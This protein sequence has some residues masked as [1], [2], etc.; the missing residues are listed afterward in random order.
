MALLTGESASRRATNFSSSNFLFSRSPRCLMTRFDTDPVSKAPPNLTF[1]WKLIFHMIL[2]IKSCFS[3]CQTT[4]AFFFNF[5]FFLKGKNKNDATSPWP[6]R[7]HNK[8]LIHQ[9]LG[10]RSSLKILIWRPVGGNPH[11]VSPPV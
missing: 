4:Q 7:Y 1:A 11:V 8:T 6:S 3:L 5:S 2:M 10:R 9:W